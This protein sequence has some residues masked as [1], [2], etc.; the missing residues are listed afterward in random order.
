MPRKELPKVE[1]HPGIAAVL[2]FV[3]WGTGYIYNGNRL[4]KGVGL[5]IFELFELMFVVFSGF[6]QLVHFP[7]II[8]LLS[9]LI[10]ALILAYDAYKDGKK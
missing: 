4:L 2:N 8:F 5:I 1:R 7:G 10:L 6:T 9:H 3:I